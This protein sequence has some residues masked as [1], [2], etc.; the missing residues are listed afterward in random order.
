MQTKTVF[1]HRGELNGAVDAAVEVAFAEVTGGTVATL[2]CAPVRDEL[3]QLG[4][5]DSRD[6]IQSHCK[7]LA[8]AHGLPVT[9]DV[10]ADVMVLHKPTGDISIHGYAGHVD[11]RRDDPLAAFTVKRANRVRKTDAAATKP[12]TRKQDAEV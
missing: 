3:D 2:P 12:K 7:H 9:H 1:G 8:E 10:A 5:E 11:R 4:C 6:K